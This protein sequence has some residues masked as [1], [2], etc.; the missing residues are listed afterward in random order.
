[1]DEY[2]REYDRHE[3]WEMLK[4]WQAEPDLKSHVDLLNSHGYEAWFDD[5][6]Y[7]FSSGDFS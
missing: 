5:E 4:S 1:M 2:D 6:G 3:F 7:E